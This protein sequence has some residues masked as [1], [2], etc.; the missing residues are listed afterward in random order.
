MEGDEL[1]SSRLILSVH[2]EGF[3]VFLLQII[4][5]YKSA[6]SETQRGD[7]CRSRNADL[8]SSGRPVHLAQQRKASASSPSSV[9]GISTVATTL[10]EPVSGR[11][12]K[13]RSIL[14]TTECK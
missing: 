2:A 1:S 7:G 14:S 12:K 6:P 9:G 5:S 13:K 3:E 4:E 11:S 10:S 8:N